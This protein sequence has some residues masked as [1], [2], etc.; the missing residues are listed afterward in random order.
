MTALG[1]LTT[2]KEIWDQIRSKLATSKGYR[3]SQDRKGIYN[4]IISF[5]KKHNSQIKFLRQGQDKR[6]DR[7]GEAL[8]P[9]SS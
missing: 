9:V 7:R 8:K 4:K 1:D 5:Y 2:S 3:V 6:N